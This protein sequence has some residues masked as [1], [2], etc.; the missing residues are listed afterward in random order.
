MAHVSTQPTTH[1]AR[2]HNE[3]IT[4]QKGHHSFHQPELLPS[5]AHT[6]CKNQIKE[7]APGMNEKKKRII[8]F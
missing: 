5:R 2:Q 8:I 4:K 3:L 1:P 7:Q 6:C